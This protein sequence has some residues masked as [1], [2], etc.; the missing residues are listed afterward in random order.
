MGRG[1]YKTQTTG[2]GLGE[3]AGGSVAAAAA[4][5]VV[6]VSCGAMVGYVG[7]SLRVKCEDEGSKASCGESCTMY[8]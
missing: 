2:V 4:A 3:A 7:L 8:L 6:A 1:T 5:V